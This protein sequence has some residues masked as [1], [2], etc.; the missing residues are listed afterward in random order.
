MYIEVLNLISFTNRLDNVPYATCILRSN[1]H[2]MAISATA[3]RNLITLMIYWRC[4]G[5]ECNN[6]L[7]ACVSNSPAP[8]VCESH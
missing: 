4:A 5:I 3:I 7:L 8:L 6:V 1:S 2:E